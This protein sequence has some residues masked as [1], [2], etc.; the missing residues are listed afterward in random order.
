[1]KSL[2]ASGQAARR[3]AQG[4]DARGKEAV[5]KHNLRLKD[6]LIAFLNNELA[7]AGGLEGD[8][9]K[10]MMVLFFAED[11]ELLEHVLT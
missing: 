9:A 4:H 2:S 3:R 5:R 1:M 8:T 11:T 10:T 6:N 7:N